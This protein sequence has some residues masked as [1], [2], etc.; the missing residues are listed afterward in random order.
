MLKMKKIKEYKEIHQ[1]GTI[2]LENMPKELKDSTIMKGDIGVQIAP[3]GRIW[4]CINHM[5]F[6]RFSPHPNGKMEK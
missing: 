6:L 2:Y 3:D 1:I 5:A 4:I